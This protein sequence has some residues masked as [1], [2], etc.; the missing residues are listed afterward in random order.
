MI[1]ELF[2]ALANQLIF[3]LKGVPLLHQIVSKS[4]YNCFLTTYHEKE[5]NHFP[6][7]GIVLVHNTESRY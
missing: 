6:L 7:R 2:E 3:L 1:D 4:I 5:S